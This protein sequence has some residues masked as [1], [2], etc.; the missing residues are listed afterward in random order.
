MA[1]SIYFVT[2]PY[3]APVAKMAMLFF[4]SGLMKPCPITR[5]SKVKRITYRFLNTY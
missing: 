2:D 5:G 3:A 4:Y 1:I